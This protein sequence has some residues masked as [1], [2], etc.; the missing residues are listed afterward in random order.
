MLASSTH[1]DI[2]K[3]TSV[4]S[5]ALSVIFHYVTCQ[6]PF[7][8]CTGDWF[9]N[10]G[11]VYCVAILGEYRGA[12]IYSKYATLQCHF[13]SIWNVYD[14]IEWKEIHKWWIRLKRRDGKQ[15]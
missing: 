13:G 2:W 3:S 8:Q 4:D 15:A 10:F 7:K 9:Q 5:D 6:L 11:Q 12:P 1:N 14:K